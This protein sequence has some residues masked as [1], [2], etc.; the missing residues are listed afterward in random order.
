MPGHRMDNARD[1]STFIEAERVATASVS[2]P[3]RSNGPDQRIQK[4]FCLDGGLARWT[5]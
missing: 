3:L 2:A 5:V 4:G 1:F